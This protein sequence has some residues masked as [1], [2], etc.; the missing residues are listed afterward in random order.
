MDNFPH[1]ED[2]ASLEVLRVRHTMAHAYA[3]MMN[4]AFDALLSFGVNYRTLAFYGDHTLLAN[5][6]SKGLV[7]GQSAYLEWMKRMESAIHAAVRR[8]QFKR[9]D[10]PPLQ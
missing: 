6:K 1:A 3:Q 10:T 7:A 9:I 2:H 8:T 4:T 5:A